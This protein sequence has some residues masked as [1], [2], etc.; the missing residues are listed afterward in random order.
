MNI[1]R[2]LKK[3]LAKLEKGK[4]ENPTLE[5]E[6]LLSFALKKGREFLFSHPE[7]EVSF[8]QNLSFERMVKKRLKG[9]SSAVITGHKWFYG[10]DLIVNKNVLV[11]RP[12]TEMMVDEVI[13]EINKSDSKTITLIDIGTGSG[14]IAIAVAKELSNK[15]IDFDLTAIDISKKALTIAKKNAKKHEVENCIKFLYSDLLSKKNL[16]KTTGAIFITANLPYLTPR[17]VE[18]SPSI[19][20]EPK[21]ALESG[22]EGL[23]HYCHLFEQLKKKKAQA[24]NKILLFCEI[25]DTQKETFSLLSKKVLPE[26]VLETKNDLNS[27]D[28]LAILRLN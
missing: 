22:A 20:K 17:Q 19:Q 18:E 28:R 9:Y 16:H 25:D 27:Q 5:A 2:T 14:C 13:K 24:K 23:D 6:L 8:W 4:I 26:A 3:A 1:E 7:I 21:I 15:E 10:L 12:E 11:P